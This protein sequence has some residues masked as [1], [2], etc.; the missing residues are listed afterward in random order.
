MILD[1][2]ASESDLRRKLRPMRKKMPR[3][4]V[5]LLVADAIVYAATVYMAAH[6]QGAAA[7]FWGAAAGIATA[8][9][10]VVGHDA[11]HGSLTASPTLN[12]WIGSLAFL[13]SLT[14]FSAWELGHNQTHHVYTNL[15]PLDYVWTPFSKAEFD[16]LP[17]WRRLLEHVYRSA[18]G[19]GLYY[20][21][22]VWWK[23]LFFAR[24]GPDGRMR[25]RDF[26]D[27]L[28]CAAYGAIVTAVALRA[29]WPA[30][31]TAVVWPFVVWNWLM[32]WAIFEH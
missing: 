32:G 15:K 25:R 10:F 7:W 14:P 12:R 22:E 4:A 24:E 19:L 6:T 8:M 11:C 2:P 31:A 21:L 29:G 23:H 5:T 20:G 28:L 30:L 18:P 26:H 13:P 16:A 3:L 9:L 1:V 17:G 27:S